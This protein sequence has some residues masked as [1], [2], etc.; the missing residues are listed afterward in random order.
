VNAT[1]DFLNFSEVKQGK[2]SRFNDS[3]GDISVLKNKAGI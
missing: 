1:V 2:K 3:S